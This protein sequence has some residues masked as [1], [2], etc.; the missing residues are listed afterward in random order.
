MCTPASASSTTCSITWRCNG[1]FDLT[2]SAHG[3]LEVDAHHTVE[4]VALALG[5]AFGQGVG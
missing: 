3:D 5:E 2:L 4:D 1:L